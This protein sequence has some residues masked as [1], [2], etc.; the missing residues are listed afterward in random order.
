MAL[1]FDG[2]G[3]DYNCSCLKGWGGVNCTHF[4]Y[5]SSISFVTIFL[6]TTVSCSA[7]IPSVSVASESPVSCYAD[8]SASNA[9]LFAILALLLVTLVSSLITTTVVIWMNSKSSK[10]RYY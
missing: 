9:V 8:V 4:L 5:T 10:P 7:S 1:C 2:P 6:T 3:L